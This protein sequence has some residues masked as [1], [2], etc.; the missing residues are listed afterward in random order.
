MLIMLPFNSNP[1]SNQSIQDLQSHSASVQLQ[2]TLK[3]ECP[4]E[5]PEKALS[6]GLEPT[7]NVY[8][9]RNQPVRLVSALTN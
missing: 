8:S 5:F 3:P 6:L 2:P 9:G 4:P 1:H 7:T